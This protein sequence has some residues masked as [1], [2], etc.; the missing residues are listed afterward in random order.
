[1]VD[2][3]LGQSNIYKAEKFGTLPSTKIILTKQ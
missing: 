3:V 2:E 1:L